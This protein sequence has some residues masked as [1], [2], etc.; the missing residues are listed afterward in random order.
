MTSFQDMIRQEAIFS[1]KVF[2]APVY[3]SYLAIR[4]ALHERS[5][6]EHVDAGNKIAAWCIKVTASGSEP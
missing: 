6:N 1:A 2:F 3:G 5:A 4:E